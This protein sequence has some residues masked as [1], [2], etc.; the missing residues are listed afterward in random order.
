MG[1]SNAQKKASAKYQAEKCKN[2]TIRFTPATMDAYYKLQ[3]QE[4]KTAF[5]VDLIRNA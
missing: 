2:V 5:L 1:A 4:N 3:Q